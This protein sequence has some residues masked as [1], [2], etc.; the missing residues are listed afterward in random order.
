MPRKR[1]TQ[2][3]VD[4]LTFV[5]L[6]AELNR[7]GKPPKP[8]MSRIDVFDEHLPGYGLRVS[9]SGSKSYFLMTRLNGKQLL[10]TIGSVEI[11][12]KVDAARERARE[13]LQLVAKGIDPRAKPEAPKAPETVRDVAAEFITRYS[14]PKNRSWKSTE[15][16]LAKHVLPVWGD[17]DVRSI[18]RADVRRLLDALT[19]GG[20]GIGVN[21]V[22]ATIRK[23]FG[24]AAERDLIDTSPALGIKAPMGEMER[25]RALSD[26]ELLQVWRAAAAV[27]GFPGALIKTLILTGQRRSEVAGMRW[28]DLDLERGVWTLPREATKGDRSHEV[29]LSPQAIAALPTGRVGEFVFAGRRSHH[30][31]P[32]SGFSKIKAALDKRITEADRVNGN[33]PIAP[34]RLHD[35]RR[36]AGTGMARLG[37]PVGTISRV[38][39]HAEGGVTKI[40][41]RHGFLDEKRQA[42]EA[43]GRHVER[44]YYSEMGDNAA[45]TAPGKVTQM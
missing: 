6:A 21:R 4:R 19:D 30:D 43:W 9:E 35:L 1:L 12:P 31:V 36:T 40:Y 3:T 25:D 39:N 33:K 10:Y 11:W 15:A 17:R 28:D 42:L 14:K 22:L 32:I 27:G 29:P 5:G 44:L 26:D 45:P 23:L 18:T 37:V 38:L 24:W 34:W 16:L 20:M 41:V 13:V 8:G 2:L 7:A